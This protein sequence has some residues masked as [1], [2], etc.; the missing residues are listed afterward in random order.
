MS[1]LENSEIFKE[2][3]GFTNE[4]IIDKESKIK[5]I[6]IN[7]LKWFDGNIIRRNSITNDNEY[8]MII[9]WYNGNDPILINLNFYHLF[10]FQY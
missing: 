5:A 10:G 7:G 6:F 9:K 2:N 1:D 3:D 8:T 4:E